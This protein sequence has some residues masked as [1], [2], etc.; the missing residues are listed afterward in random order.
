MTWLVAPANARGY[1]H[2]KH[3]HSY[4][5]HAS[6]KHYSHRWRN[7]HS[8]SVRYADGRPRAWC[9][10]Y[11]AHKLGIGGSKGRSLWLAANWRYMGQATQASIGAIV[12]WA[13]HVGQI[14]GGSPGRWVINSGNDGH[15]VRTRQRSIAG[16]IAIRRV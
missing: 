10:W 11:M 13:H 14:V 2:Y 7:R 6:Y 9:G 3:H 5:H 16:A 4:S 12:V 15:A 8:R 1:H